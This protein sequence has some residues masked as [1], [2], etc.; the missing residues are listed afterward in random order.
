[1]SVCA[2][3]QIAPAH[4]GS[5]SAVSRSART[6]SNFRYAPIP[7]ARSENWRPPQ[8]A[9]LSGSSG[10]GRAGCC[11][12]DLRHYCAGLC[13]SD[14]ANALGQIIGTISFGMLTGVNVTLIKA[15]VALVPACVLLAGRSLCSQ[16]QRPLRRC[17][18][19][20]DQELCCWWSLRM[21]L[22]R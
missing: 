20:W 16:R 14:V 8:C 7:D 18:S 5:I 17:Y 2:L 3:Q 13:A 11:W 19:Y 6:A 21:C 1:M 9:G 12:S 15:L 10:A 22:K 4:V